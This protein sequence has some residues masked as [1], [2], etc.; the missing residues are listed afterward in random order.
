MTPPDS[1]TIVRAHGRR[2]AKTIHADGAIDKYGK[3][4]IFDLIV[5]P[6][7]D[8]AALEVVLR[9]LAELHDCAVVRGTP[10][11]PAFVKGV[12]RLLHR[13]CDA[14]DPP[15]LVEAPH[16]W[17]A[18]DIDQLSRPDWIKPEDL[19]GC[20]C[21]A[22]RRTLP[23]EFHQARFVVQA[24]ASHGLK[25]GIRLRLWAWL[26]RPVFGAELKYWFRLSL[27]DHSIFGANQVIYTATPVFLPGAF[28]PLPKRIDAIPGQDVVSVPPPDQL[29]PP[30]P[31]SR[32]PRL[33]GGNG[34]IS[35][36]IRVVAN[37][38]PGNRNAI[39]Y[40]AGCRA[41]EQEGLNQNAAARD[42]IAAAVAAGLPTREASATVE[43]AL[44]GGRL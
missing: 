26:A 17:I 38:R 11:D 35:G 42:L 44:R 21:V 16:R 31:Q 1:I 12:R 15:T 27:V 39:L 7:A 23:S 37:A 41:A 34:N 5:H 3:A 32:R 8:C 36:L 13:D 2:L 20:A 24:T 28:D 18:I 33:G 6:I 30:A 29:K 43:S 25:P 19:L 10:A 14:G 40:W 4:K 22:I 9:D